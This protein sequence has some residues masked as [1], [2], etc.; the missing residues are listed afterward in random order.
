M[1]RLLPAVLAC[2]LLAGCGRTDEPP[3][4]AASETIPQEPADALPETAPAHPIS[5]PAVVTEG[6]V[7]EKDYELPSASTELGDWNQE[8]EPLALLARTE[9]VALYGI[10]GEK[11]RILLCWG[12]IEAEF[13]WSYRTPRAIPPQCWQIDVDGDGTEDAVVVC[14]CEAVLRSLWN[15]STL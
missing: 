6:R 12:D 8:E 14:Y 2:L 3:E 10:A 9:D 13:P 4:S 15:N 5:A 11:D 7:P 1:R